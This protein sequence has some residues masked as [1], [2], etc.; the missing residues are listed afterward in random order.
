MLFGRMR[1]SAPVRLIPCVVGG[2][3]VPLA[4][5]AAVRATL[6][7]FDGWFWLRAAAVTLVLYAAFT[8]GCRLMAHRAGTSGAVPRPVPRWSVPRPVHRIVRRLAKAV[9]GASARV[10]AF[11]P[12]AR[13]AIAAA[14]ILLC[15]TPVIMLMLPGTIWYDTGDQ[16]TQFL[17]VVSSGGA[18]GSVS[19]HHPVF[20]TIVFGGAAWIGQAVAGDI[21]VG[22]GVYLA[23]QVAVT[24]SELA[25]VCLYVH[26]LGLG[27][28]GTIVM[29]AFFAL[30]PAFPIFTMSIVK[31]TLHMM[32]LIPW[33]LMVVE[34]TRTRLAAL[35]SRRFLIGFVVVSS[36]CALTTMTGLYIVVLTLCCLPLT[37]GRRGVR[38]AAAGCA[39]AVALLSGVAFPAAVRGPLHV[40]AEDANQ[41]LVVPMQMTARY[42]LDHPGDVTSHER[43]IIDRV[44]RVPFERMPER[45]NPYLADTV[46]HYSL[47]DPAA[48]PE[49]LGVWFAMGLRHPDSYV[50]AFVSLESG[51]C[52][53]MRTPLNTT[54]RGISLDTLDRRAGDAVGNTM[55]FQINDAV[56]PSFRPLAK[57]M[58]RL[59]GA[60]TDRS[61]AYRLWD[62]WRGAPVVGLLTFTALWT[63]ILPLFLVFCRIGRGDG[64]RAVDSSVDSSA[65]RGRGR[66]WVPFAVPLVWSLAS[67]LPNAISVPLKPTATR[68]MMWALV[69]LP[70]LL[71]LLRADMAAPDRLWAEEAVGFGPRAGRP[72]KDRP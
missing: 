22:L 72:G 71:A 60:S 18:S 48:V 70:L 11:G 24:C 37:R 7:P 12:A 27:R 2:L 21:G 29:L 35:A 51:W 4:D 42:A 25:G 13:L 26:S 62:G 69:M 63:F 50:T 39:A 55:W 15:W 17:T 61:G 54:S 67:L 59:P 34:A 56:S 53:L 16:I 30:F 31:D 66:A 40:R 8:A 49:Y 23:V 57:R 6:G 36:L 43:G 68:Y 41:L 1:P 52:S 5:H 58:G 46:I 20:D 45:Y 28:A 47:R 10:G 14:I 33:L 44:S 32:F 64:G 38:A 3:I 65:A 19:S 9:H